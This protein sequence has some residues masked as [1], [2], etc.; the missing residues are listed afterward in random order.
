M[1]V[2]LSLSHASVAVHMRKALYSIYIQS[3]IFFPSLLHV[4]SFFF[5][6]V[7]F[8][9]KRN[10][11]GKTLCQA[12]YSTNPSQ[13]FKKKKSKNF[14]FVLVIRSGIAPLKTVRSWRFRIHKQKV[15]TL[16]LNNLSQHTSPQIL[17]SDS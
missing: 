5:H 13:K 1:S 11:R 15:K 6:Q 2:L 4:V 8:I 17:I 9:S 7:V 12:F 3:R 16:C 10:I 14:G